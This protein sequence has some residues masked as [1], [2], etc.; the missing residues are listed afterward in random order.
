MPDTSMSYRQYCHEPEILYDYAWART[1]SQSAERLAGALKLRTT[2]DL[3]ALYCNAEIRRI[4]TMFWESLESWKSKSSEFQVLWREFHGSATTTPAPPQIDMQ[5]GIGKTPKHVF[6]HWC[7]TWL[8]RLA[9]TLFPRCSLDT[10]PPKL[11]AY[12]YF[13]VLCVFRLWKNRHRWANDP[14]KLPVG[15]AQSVRWH[16]QPSTDRLG[17]QPPVSPIVI[18]IEE[19]ATPLTPTNTLEPKHALP[20]AS[21]GDDTG[22]PEQPIG[23]YTSARELLYQFAGKL[24]EQFQQVQISASSYPAEKVE[25]ASAQFADIDGL[26][27]KYTQTLERSC[28]GVTAANNKS[29]SRLLGQIADH[30]VQMGNQS[31]GETGR[32]EE[33]GSGRDTGLGVKHTGKC[34]QT[35]PKTQI[36]QRNNGVSKIRTRPSKVLNAGLNEHIQAALNSELAGTSVSPDQLGAVHSNTRGQLDPVDSSTAIE[37]DSVIEVDLTKD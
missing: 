15:F 34:F 11:D 33:I 36:S 26:V 13:H 3:V 37:L 12:D 1:M 23:D 19:P 8:I 7:V 17:I 2:G 30:C 32:G 29:K 35:A 28:I 10:T 27:E 16:R 20:A 18:G 31:I 5:N 21:V 4:I 6:E 25:N 24:C 22:L 9:P 14:W